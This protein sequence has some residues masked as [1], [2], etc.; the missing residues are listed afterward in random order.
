MAL[1][2]HLMNAGNDLKTEGG[3]VHFHW[4]IREDL[5]HCC[6]KVCKEHIRGFVNLGR[7]KIQLLVVQRKQMKELIFNYCALIN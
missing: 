6:Q 2:W 7:F 5:S 1:K 3:I 4:N